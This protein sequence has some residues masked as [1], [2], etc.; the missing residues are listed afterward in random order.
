MDS[1][2]SSKAK[3]ST[4]IPWAEVKK[5]GNAGDCWVIVDG[6]VYD[7]SQVEHPGGLAGEF[8][9]HVHLPQTHSQTIV[10][11]AQFHSP[12]QKSY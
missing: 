7:L 6:K 1:S 10:L 11:T 4:T 12:R 8:Y 3:G 5:H 2:T 9:T